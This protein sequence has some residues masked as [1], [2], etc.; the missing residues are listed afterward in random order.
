[1]G[2][3]LPAERIKDAVGREMKDRLIK[4]G[5]M[6][7]LQMSCSFATRKNLSSSFSNAKGKIFQVKTD[8]TSKMTYPEP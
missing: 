8:F 2:F 4:Q 6:G 5:P 1:M 3:C 7:H